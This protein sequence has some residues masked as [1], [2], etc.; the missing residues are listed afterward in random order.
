MSVLIWFRLHEVAYMEDIKKEFL[1]ISLSLKDRD[2][3][4][5]L[6]FAGSPTEDEGKRESAAHDQSCACPFVLAATVRGHL[7]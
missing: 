2:A 3:V 7:R 1:Q 5:F 4:R 6:W